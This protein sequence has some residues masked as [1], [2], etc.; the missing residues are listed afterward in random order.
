M[1]L[2][3][4]S[5]VVL[6]CLFSTELLYLV[7]LLGS[8]PFHLIKHWMFNPQARYKQHPKTAVWCFPKPCPYVA[9]C[10]CVGYLKCLLGSHAMQQHIAKTTYTEILKNMAHGNSFKEEIIWKTCHFDKMH[11]NNYTSEISKQFLR[12]GHFSSVHLDFSVLDLTNLTIKLIMIT[13]LEG[14]F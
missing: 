10:I 5:Y 13:N 12:I 7:S 14:D 4:V 9:E 6:N 11:R 3:T 1:K 8:T 2:T